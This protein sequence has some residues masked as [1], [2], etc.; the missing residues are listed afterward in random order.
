MSWTSE[1]NREECEVS[2]EGNQVEGRSIACWKRELPN[3]RDNAE[4]DRTKE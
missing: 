3:S 2:W 1:S 4:L